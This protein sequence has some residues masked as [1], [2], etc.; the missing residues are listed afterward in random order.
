[1]IQSSECLRAAPTND[2]TDPVSEVQSWPVVRCAIAKL[3]DLDFS[4]S[5]CLSG[6]GSGQI[7]LACFVEGRCLGIAGHWTE[8]FVKVPVISNPS[9]IASNILLVEDDGMPA[10][11]SRHTAEYLMVLTRLNWAKMV[12]SSRTT[13]LPGQTH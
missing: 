9:E 5:S 4:W 10:T 11:P 2:M 1:M 6:A 12:A 3:H 8:L 13:L 7:G